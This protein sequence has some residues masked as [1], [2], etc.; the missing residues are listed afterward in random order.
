MKHKI[1]L[2][3]IFILLLSGLAAY[4]WQL[5]NGY[6][7]LSNNDWRLETSLSRFIIIAIPC[8]FILYMLLRVVN[9]FFGLVPRLKRYSKNKHIS[10]AHKSTISGLM[11]LLEGRWA[12]AEK[13]FLKDIEHN[14]SSLLNYLLAARAAHNSDNLEKRDQ[15][16]KAAHESTPEAD[17]AI[18]ITQ[19]DLQISAQQYD[20]ALATLE[21][22]LKISPKHPYIIKQISRLY[23]QLKD[24]EKFLNILPSARS[25][26]VFKK[27]E[28]I[29]LEYQAYHSILVAKSASKNV[30]V[31]SSI[32]KEAPSELKSD[33][34]FINTYTTELN[35]F[36]QTSKAQAEKIL[37]QYI[38]KSW[39]EDLVRQYGLIKLEDATKQ[40]KTAEKWNN[41]HGR[42]PMLM[43]TLARLCSR[44]QLWG[45]AR[46][47]YESSIAL[48]PTS[49]AYLELAELL[50]EKLDEKD[51]STDVLRAGLDLACQNNQDRRTS[52]KVASD[53]ASALDTTSSSALLGRRD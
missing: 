22:L 21:Q 41:G 49:V 37:R 14:K 45:K 16:L 28:L 30:D 10:N 19:A 29:S 1:L 7:L 32:W 35:K 2:F 9:Y 24:W 8:L 20:M 47:Y 5:N 4:F 46:V 50:S 53:S 44:L 42:S 43:L 18:G 39:D 26:K 40:L 38:N 34:R 13:S 3:I 48:L 23:V 27:D 15:F 31:L 36:E 17:V 52:D 6:V 12:K 11:F 25:H 51:K 33:S